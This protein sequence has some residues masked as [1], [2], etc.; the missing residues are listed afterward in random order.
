MACPIKDSCPFF[1]NL[2]RMM[3]ERKKTLKKRF[4]LSSYIQCARFKIYQHFK[5]TEKVP[6]DLYPNNY[7]KA[8]EFLQEDKKQQKHKKHGGY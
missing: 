4:C 6:A 8:N 3:E 7:E 5:S 2:M 1:N